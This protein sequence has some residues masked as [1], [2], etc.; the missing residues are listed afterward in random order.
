LKT[1]AVNAHA[2]KDGMTAKDILSSRLMMT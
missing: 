2:R 1:N